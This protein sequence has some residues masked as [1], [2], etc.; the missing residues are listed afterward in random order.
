MP[1]GACYARARSG[2]G[3]KGVGGDCREALPMWHLIEDFF[4]QSIVMKLFI[5]V[6]WLA[7]VIM[8]LSL[9]SPLLN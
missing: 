4:E 5:A 7:I 1:R 9:V 8:L 6:G 3:A 2:T